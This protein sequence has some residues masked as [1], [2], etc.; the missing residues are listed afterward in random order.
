MRGELLNAML[1][2]G[3]FRES[4]GLST[5]ADSRLRKWRSCSPDEITWA[6]FDN[7]FVAFH[8]P[9]GKT[10]FLNAA[11]YALLNDLLNEPQSLSAV[12]E[13]FAADDTEDKV[14]GFVEQMKAMLT[15]L[16]AL[17]LIVRA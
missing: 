4:S 13:M 6:E 10:H 14:D 1:A 7:E 15:H 5:E 2:T 11:S 8:R 12:L 17:G 3:R 9:S 16:E